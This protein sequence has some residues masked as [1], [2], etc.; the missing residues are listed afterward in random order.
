MK[1]KI[2]LPI[3]WIFLVICAN[4]QVT[5]GPLQPSS[6]TNNAS[7]G[8]VSW[9]NPTNVYSSDGNFANA[10]ALA[11]GTNSEYLVVTNFGFSI[12][13]ESHITGITVEIE[14]K[15]TKVL[16]VV[17][18]AVVTD[19]SVM[20]VKNGIIGGIDHASGDTWST[21][22]AVYA[23]YGNSS[24]DWGHTWEASDVN[25]SDFGVA[26][27]ASFGGLVLPN[28]QIDNIRISVHYTSTLFARLNYFVAQCKDGE[29]STTWEV[30]AQ[31]NNDYFTLERSDDGFDFSELERIQG[32]G[33]S[34]AALLYSAI[35]ENRSVDPVYYRLSQT[36]YDGTTR[37]LET[38]RSTCSQTETLLLYPNPSRGVPVQIAYTYKKNSA[39][40]IRLR[41]AYGHVFQTHQHSDLMAPLIETAFLSSGIYLVELLENDVLLTCQKL[42]IE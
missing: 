5:V 29:V 23:T 12:P 11:I 36:D 15:T 14:K 8:T 25:A 24:D 10:A 42:I 7:I 26:I 18:S 32:A 40:S 27:S 22:S 39:Y 20:I 28:A 17:G 38:I 3:A 37:V 41:D 31:H 13:E 35:D 2:A 21:G 4:A 1:K 19:N 34:N 30:A 33:T 16:V 9:S 6:A